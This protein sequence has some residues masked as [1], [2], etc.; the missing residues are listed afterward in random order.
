MKNKNWNTLQYFKNNLGKTYS[1][2][3]TFGDIEKDKIFIPIK[4]AFRSRAY[5]KPN[6][7]VVFPKKY[8]S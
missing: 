1:Y 7:V 8:V 5:P 3:S 6:N 2:Q 4:I